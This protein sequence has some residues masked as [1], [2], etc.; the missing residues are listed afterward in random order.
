MRTPEGALSRYRE[1][2]P[3]DLD[4]MTFNHPANDQPW[5]DKR[6]PDGTWQI[7]VWDTR[8]SPKYGWQCYYGAYLFYKRRLSYVLQFIRESSFFV[9]DLNDKFHTE[10]RLKNR[11]TGATIPFSL[12]FANDPEYHEAQ[13]RRRERDR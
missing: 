4:D 7:E 13:A 2:Y 9:D 3:R 1:T 8:F 5:E 10:I 12:L 6:L 11:R